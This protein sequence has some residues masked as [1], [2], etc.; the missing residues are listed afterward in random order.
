MVAPVD[1]NGRVLRRGEEEQRAGEPDWEETIF[2]AAIDAA[3]GQNWHRSSP[4][5]DD[6]RR[7]TQGRWLSLVATLLG[8]TD[9]NQRIQ[10]QLAERLGVAALD[11]IEAARTYRTAVGWRDRGKVIAGLLERLP[12]RRCLCDD[13]L[14]CGAIA[15]LWGRPSRWDPGGPLG[16]VVVSLFRK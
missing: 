4:S 5:D 11:L 9:M 14:V 7:R 16:G 8:L 3:E 2:S 15:G 10:E 6:R 12:I 1:E 13:L